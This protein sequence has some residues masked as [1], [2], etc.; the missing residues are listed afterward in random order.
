MSSRKTK[1][2]ISED[3]HGFTL[4]KGGRQLY[5]GLS[6]RQEA[7]RRLKNHYRPGEQ[8]ML[9]EDDGYLSNITQQLKRTGII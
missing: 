3:R 8:V 5:S 4:T 1:W 6:S 7:L 2:I 9:E